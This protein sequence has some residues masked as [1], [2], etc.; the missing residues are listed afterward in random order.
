LGID[1]QWQNS[2]YTNHNDETVTD[3]KTGLM[4]KQCPEGLSRSGCSAGTAIKYTYKEAIED[5]KSS[6]FAGHNDW[7][8]P[9]IKELTSLVAR[10]RYRPAINST[11]FPKTPHAYRP[12]YANYSDFFWSSSPYANDADNARI[13]NF[14]LGYGYNSNRGNDHSV[15]L[16][17]G[18]Q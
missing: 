3:T 9:N 15:R 6:K 5:A 7:R 18:G 10:D 1:N 16:V 11:L 14:Y 13:L 8:L 2:R 17:R 12:N 4:W